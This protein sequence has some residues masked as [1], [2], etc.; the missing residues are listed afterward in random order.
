MS[1][2]FLG[3]RIDY[4]SNDVSIFYEVCAE[5][6]F[7]PLG[8][9]GVQAKSALVAPRGNNFFVIFFFGSDLFSQMF[10]GLL[11]KMA[12]QIL[13]VFFRLMHVLHLCDFGRPKHGQ[14]STPLS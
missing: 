8:A 14:K 11:T 4:L 12:K 3:H 13:A 5:K 6:S 1:T 2:V 9:T 7:F 10:F